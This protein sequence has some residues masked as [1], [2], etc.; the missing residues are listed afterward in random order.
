MDYLFTNFKSA[1]V[2][3]HNL[4]YDVRLVRS[5]FNVDKVLEKGRQIFTETFTR[6]DHVIKFIDSYAKIHYK[7]SLFPKIFDIKNT[8]KEI[9]PYNYY[10]TERIFCGS[11]PRSLGRISEVGFD[12][13][14]E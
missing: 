11:A 5:K 1:V 6:N 10:T 7:L 4:A 8:V 13:K 14:P 12:E 3:F 2:I 9:F